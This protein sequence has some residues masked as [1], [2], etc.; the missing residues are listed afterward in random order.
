MPLLLAA[1]FR[2]R[3]RPRSVLMP[4]PQHDWARFFDAHAP[5]YM[6]NVFTRNTLGEVDFLVAHL[7]LEPGARLLDIGCGAGRHSV[8]LTR[9]GFRVTG[10]DISA[11]MLAQAQKAA[12]AAGVT[13][14]WIQ[15]DATRFTASSPYDAAICLCEGAF[16]LLDLADDPFD[17]DLAILRNVHAALV[18]AGGFL[19]T[20]LNGMR[21][22]REFTDDDV[23]SGRFDPNTLTD[24]FTVEEGDLSVQVKERSYVPSELALL[25]RVA[26]FRVEHL[27]GGTA[28]SWGERRVRLDEIEI[29]ALARRQ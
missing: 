1:L 4:D 25:L 26:G 2:V 3:F 17:H 7:G 29:M 14:E 10:V 8:E 19:L 23:E 28:G 12:A 11:G 22:I 27:W 6:T 21:K 24:R 15:E 16:A 9:R 13:V 20:T 5:N 18:P